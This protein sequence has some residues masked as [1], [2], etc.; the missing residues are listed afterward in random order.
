MIIKNIFGN[1]RQVHNHPS[2][3]PA[4]SRQD[5]DITRQIVE[6]GKRLGIAVH[7]HIIIGEK[8]HTSL[9]AQGLL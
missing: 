7:D 2:G 9:R 3:D 4:P 5:I 1:A 6:A 8:G